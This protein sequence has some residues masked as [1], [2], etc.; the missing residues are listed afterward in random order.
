MLIYKQK[1]MD[2]LLII[3]GA[4]CII[5]GLIGCFLPVLPGPPLSY[6]GLVLLH[7]TSVSDFSWSF[8]LLWAIIVA[9]VQVLDY[10]LP[11]W[12]TKK[13]GGGRR[14]SWGSAL[15]VIV[16]V[17]VFPPLGIIIFPFVG[18]VLGEIS[19]GKSFTASFKAGFGSFLGFI[20]GVI[21]KLVVASSLAYF[22]IKEIFFLF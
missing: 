6:L 1:D 19:E 16:G 7:F 18:A 12:G 17:F 14:G 13:F 10:Y 20:G 5:V 8:F 15:G 21:F 9:L 22:F 2:Y 3:V 4:I 11:I